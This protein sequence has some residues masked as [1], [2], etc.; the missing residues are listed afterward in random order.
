MKVLEEKDED[1][2]AD[3]MDIVAIIICKETLNGIKDL[4]IK[5]VGIPDGV[6]DAMG[7]AMGQVVLDE[8]IKL[9]ENLSREELVKWYAE[10]VISCLVSM[11]NHNPGYFARIV[12][13]IKQQP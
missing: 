10:T 13:L 2:Y 5:S 3:F 1:V 12:T 6:S 8:V 4:N 7:M 9:T 11:L